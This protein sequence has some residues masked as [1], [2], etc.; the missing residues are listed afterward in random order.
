MGRRAVGLGTGVGVVGVLVAGLGAVQLLP[1][2][3]PGSAPPAAAA[4]LV[5][6]DGCAPLLQA[7]RSHLRETATAYG[8]GA[9]YGRAVAAS[10][11]ARLESAS[12][13][14]A[15]GPTGTN[16]QEVGVDE[17]DVA[18]L[19]DGLLV[20]VAQGALQ[21]VRAGAQPVQLAALPMQEEGGA[22]RARGHW[23][24]PRAELLLD[25]D[26][27]L[28]VQPSGSNG[29]FDV[30]GAGS[31]TSRTTLRLA[32]LSDPAAPRWLESWQV[33]GSYVSAR[34]VDGTVRLVTRTTPAPEPVRAL[35]R[36]PAQERAGLL[37]H[38][39]AAERLPLERVLPRA[40]HRGADGEVL[41]DGPSLA[42]EQVSA[43]PGALGG[44][45]L[46]VTTLRPSAG[47]SPTHAAGVTADG[48]LVYAARERLYVATSRW[49]TSQG[50]AAGRE[51]ERGSVTTQLHA[52]DTSSPDRTEHVAT[53]DVPGW[54]LG[55]W[56]LSWHEG[57]LRVATTLGEPWSSG[58]G[59]SSTVTVLRETGHD[60]RAVG[61][62]GGLGPGER[63]QAV[64]YLGDLA[65]VVTFRQTDP[66]YVLDLGRPEAPR[67]LGEL[68]VPGFSTYLHPVGDGRLLGVGM[69]ADARGRTTGMQASL[70]DLTDLRRPRQTS[71]LPL[72]RV[73]SP[74]QEDSRAFGYDPARRL[75]VVPVASGAST[76][77]LGIQVG[78][79]GVLRPAGRLRVGGSVTVDR[80]LSDGA[81]VY[82]V[83]GAGI[84]AGDAAG[85]ARTGRVSYRR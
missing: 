18:K 76:T 39:A 45:L 41:S 82:A 4:G 61:R 59:S 78:A 37:A 43:A 85:L 22:D 52:F 24:G 12:G 33:D 64:R 73:W 20:S 27:A 5:P 70:F 75:A 54:V 38:R 30:V 65:T 71:R 28:V 23:W 72:G 2:G 40:V 15:A 56:A 36:T 48:D 42:C 46:Q 31:E 66:L 6:Y 84:V 50:P 17:P 26:R 83:S 14:V 74:V 25:G 29:T 3:T 44:G 63:I 79:D 32:D 21:V 19:A 58:P 69:E 81:L 34:L 55:R 9:G 10:A 51:R 47:L 67:L 53:G 49:G 35:Y 7:Y 62:V 13:A 68:K 8:W 60:L 57:A 16:V 11:D 80:V 1:S 77:A